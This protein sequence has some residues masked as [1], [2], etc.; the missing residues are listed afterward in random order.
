PIMPFVSESLWQALPEAAFERGLPN[1]EPAAQSVVIAPWPAYPDSWR[2][3]DMERRMAR[4]QELVRAVRE[5]R[6]RYSV[7]PKTALDVSVRCNEKV[8]EEFRSLKTFIA[9]LAS[10]GRFTY[11]PDVVKPK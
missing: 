4:M 9:A 10:V 2:N 5:V 11:G 6:N 8:A 7:D 3:A 1:P